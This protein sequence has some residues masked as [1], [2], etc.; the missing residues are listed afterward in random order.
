MQI[1]DV[2]PLCD[3]IYCTLQCQQRT[4]NQSVVELFKL[5][6]KHRFIYIYTSMYVDGLSIHT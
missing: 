6:R 5:A 4:G 2:T 1:P 3:Q